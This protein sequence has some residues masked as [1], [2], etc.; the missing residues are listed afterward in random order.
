[1]RNM[2]PCHGARC[3]NCDGVDVRW[4]S[5]FPS[6]SIEGDVL[7]RWCY[8]CGNMDLDGFANVFNDKPLQAKFVV[9]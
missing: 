8:I 5:L 6:V 7:L 1:M 4:R 2:D 3:R 9:T